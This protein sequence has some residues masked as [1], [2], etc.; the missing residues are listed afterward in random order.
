VLLHQLT[1]TGI[2]LGDT[3]Y[4]YKEIKKFWIIYNPPHVK[5]L[6][7]ENHSLPQPPSQHPNGHEDPGELKS[8][9]KNTFQKT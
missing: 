5:I 9:L 1:G 3:V 4:P 6:N 8:F 2:A 7:I